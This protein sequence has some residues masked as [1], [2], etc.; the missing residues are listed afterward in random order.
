M[1]LRLA[2]KKSHMKVHIFSIRFV[3]FT[4]DIFFLPD[5]RLYLL[6]FYFYKLYIFK[7]VSMFYLEFPH[8]INSFFILFMFLFLMIF[9]NT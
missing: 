6:I 5:F 8:I 2:L 7:C 1:D 3:Y 4:Y 9:L